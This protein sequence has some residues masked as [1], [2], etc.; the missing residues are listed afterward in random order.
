MECKNAVLLIRE[1]D[2][3]ILSQKES[4][5]GVIEDKVL[6]GEDVAGIDR[7]NAPCVCLCAEYS[8]CKSAF[9]IQ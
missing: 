3:G 2:L 7:N 4:E 1:E 8:Q 9:R 5:F 6:A